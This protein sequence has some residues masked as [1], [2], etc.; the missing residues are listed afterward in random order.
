MTSH[1]FT[2][3]II[4]PEYDLNPSLNLNNFMNHSPTISE[5][6]FDQG[7][8]ICPDVPDNELMDN[9]YLNS[10]VDLNSEQP[11]YDSGS[12]LT[13]I[14]QLI[15]APK[16]LADESSLSYE[17]N[18]LS[19][20]VSQS[21]YDQ[22]SNMDTFLLD[23]LFNEVSGENAIVQKPLSAVNSKDN[24]MTLEAFLSQHNIDVEQLKQKS[25]IVK[26]R[27]AINNRNIPY[28]PCPP[29]VRNLAKSNGEK[30]R[31]SYELRKKKHKGSYIDLI[32][33]ED[34]IPH[35]NML[36]KKESN[37][38][39]TLCALLLINHIAFT[40][41]S[42]IAFVQC[43]HPFWMKIA[44]VTFSIASM[45][46]TLIVTFAKQSKHRTLMG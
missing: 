34:T 39:R 24:F 1:E 18:I 13:N 20:I 15:F 28:V 29:I 25:I 22:Q 16:S 7:N 36:K 32:E 37:S 12:F 11:T 31:K 45:T 9:V 10:N 17:T 4:S 23:S 35:T 44:S 21:M 3:H 30:F 2:S 27:S 8:L 43:Q 33:C 41:K 38:L 42:L 14:P 40:I 19:S 46:A 26:H 6:F 5:K